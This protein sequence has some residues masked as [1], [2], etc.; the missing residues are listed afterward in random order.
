MSYQPNW[1]Q[2]DGGRLSPGKHWVRDDDLLDI[3]RELNRRRNLGYV[4]SQS[5]DNQVAPG[6]LAR[7]Y[8]M[9]GLSAPP[10]DSLRKAAMDILSM[11]A[12]LSGGVPASPAAVEWLWPDAGADYGKTIVASMP[13]A[14][15]VEL[16]AKL[17][18]PSGWTDPN[19]AGRYIR[20][21]HVNELRW[22][23]EKVCR[24][25]WRLPVYSIA[26]II[27][28][29][30]DSG[31]VGGIVAR[32][33]YSE[34]RAMAHV[35][36]CGD[37]EFG[38]LGQGLINVNVL[39]SSLLHVTADQPCTIGVYQLLRHIDFTGNPPSWRWYDPDGGLEW[40]SPG[41]L[42]GGDAAFLGQVTIPANGLGTIS[43]AALTGAM[44][45]MVDGQESNFIFA[46]VDSSYA[47]AAFT[48]EAAVDF[49]LT[50]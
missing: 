15:Q 5:I 3:A 4:N 19:L 25:R 39:P 35:T 24:G 10:F 42:G 21:V 31:W 27:S 44:Q 17:N 41:G 20:A 40:T 26:G 18:T 45:N 33:V 47:A 30:P 8:T 2:G 28:V 16:L 48:A 1:T 14:G 49:E 34:V 50:S 23:M 46:R 43:T 7:L 37:G 22:C 9:Q 36:M 11:P 29:M 12:G 38:G 13:Q 32:N 6:L